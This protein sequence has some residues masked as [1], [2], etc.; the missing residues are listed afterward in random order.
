MISRRERWVVLDVGETLIDES[1]IWTAWADEL[2]IPRTTFMSVFGSIVERGLGYQHIREYFPIA[3]WSRHRDA[4]EVAL[5]GFQ[6]QDL[7]PDALPTLRG[8]REQG[9]RTAVI[10]NQRTERKEQ[11]RSL[12]VEAEV[13][14]MSG[15]MGVEKP[16]P[17]FFR[18]ALRSL[19]EPPPAVVAYVGDR[20]DND[21]QPAAAAGM[22]AVWLRRGP[23]G[24]IPREVPPEAHLVVGS[25]AELARRV[26][27]VWE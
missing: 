13:M 2:R 22:R 12:G 6:A 18:A 25:L 23:W 7:Y 10:A 20:I 15:E 21:V 1:R 16:D 3:D 27:E 5:D 26:S 14:L 4:V 17:A 19:G 8:L 9:Y 24:V 11:L